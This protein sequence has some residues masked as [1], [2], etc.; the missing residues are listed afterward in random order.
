MTYQVC[1]ICNTKVGP[2]RAGVPLLGL[3]YSCQ[4][5]ADARWAQQELD[6]T[7]ESEDDES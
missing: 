2:L 6:E 3:C 5:D 1:G 4:E 7:I